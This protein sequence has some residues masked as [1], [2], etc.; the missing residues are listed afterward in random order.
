MKKLIYK[1]LTKENGIKIGMDA[2]D[3][4]AEKLTDTKAINNFVAAYKTKC[5][6]GTIKLAQVDDLLTVEKGEN[7][8]FGVKNFAYK[9]KDNVNVYN[10]LKKQLDMDVTQ[11]SLLK[12]GT[13]QKIF[14]MFY[15][16]KFTKY[17]LEDE[18]ECIKLDLGGC[19]TDIFLHDNIFVCLEGE[20]QKGI[21]KVRRAYL[22]IPT[23]ATSE[24]QFLEDRSFKICCIND[25]KKNEKEIYDIY[26]KHAPDMYVVSCQ[27]TES[28][29]SFPV[30][31]IVCKKGEENVMPCFF[32]GKRRNDL[33]HG[34]NPCVVEFKQ[35]SVLFLDIEW[36]KYKE[37]GVFINQKPLDAF[38]YTFL[39]QGSA[40]PFIKAD[41]TLKY[42]PNVVVL[43]GNTKPFIKKVF[44][45]TVVSLPSFKYK[46][47]AVID[48]QNE[49]VEIF[50]E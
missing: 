34:T 26:R 40:N 43:F 1:V 45:T 50:T 16:D 31:S 3:Y 48:A 25:I 39:S 38:L 22:S 44:D 46:K 2:L 37:S 23:Y 32:E 33:V 35:K 12:E 18:H 19:E 17:V 30:S 27:N 20:K 29:G 24:N 10:V 7:A 13:L 5:K 15:R 49:N 6:S 42:T 41:V 36:T 21:F 9:A 28:I 47:Y 14:G 11:I 8:C 4:L